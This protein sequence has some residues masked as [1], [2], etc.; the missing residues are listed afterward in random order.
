[1]S[2][3]VLGNSSAQ[4]ARVTVVIT[5][6]NRA[7]VLGNAIRS[8]KEQDV[9][10]NVLVVDDSS[11]DGGPDM[12]KRDF[13][14]VHLVENKES[15]GYIVRRNEGAK[16]ATTEF[17]ISIDDDAIFSTP[18]VVRQSLEYFD[19]P[20]VG[21]VM[22]PHKDIVN[23]NVMGKYGHAPDANETYVVP[24][25]IG[26]AHIVRRELFCK[27]GGYPEDYI[28]WGEEAV[29]CRKLLNAGYFVRVAVSDPI[30][31][32]PHS[33]GR[34]GPRNIFIYRNRTL[35]IARDVPLRYLPVEYSRM[36]ASL[37]RDFAKLPE[38]RGYVLR[39]LWQ[40][41]RDSIRSFGR[42]SP[43]SPRAFKMFRFLRANRMVSVTK[44]KQTFPELKIG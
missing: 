27:L 15:R 39:G 12:V 31:H 22:I 19:K 16:L 8:C 11:T 7:D 10:V 29:Y 32:L 21:A 13:P 35:G 18:S 1:M 24:S 26:C 5:T 43:L 6:K 20:W 3:S 17:V 44:L 9:P 25:Y 2:Q 38:E 36:F 4:Q 30:H 37:V 23:G 41:M 34:H 33:L 14:W 28:H 42:R 40:G